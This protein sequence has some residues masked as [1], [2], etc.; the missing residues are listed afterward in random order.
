MEERWTCSGWV[1][2][3]RTA[4][5]LFPTEQA[6]SFPRFDPVVIAVGIRGQ[7]WDGAT[8][9]QTLRYAV[10]TDDT[11]PM[12]NTPNQDYNQP[13]RCAQD[14]H[15]PLNDNF[16]KLD[17]DVPIVDTEA[18]RGDYDP[19]N[20]SLFFATDTGHVYLW[21][22][23]DWGPLSLTWVGRDGTDLFEPVHGDD[24]VGGIAVST[25][26]LDAD[27][28]S[29]PSSSLD[30]DWRQPGPG[31]GVD[32]D[33]V[34]GVGGTIDKSLSGGGTLEHG[35]NLTCGHP[36]NTV[37][38]GTAGATICGGGGEITT[39]SGSDSLSNEVGGDFGV[40]TGGQDNT[41]DGELGTV[42][43]GGSNSCTG[44][45]GTVAG[46]SGNEATADGA[47]VGG[48]FSNSAMD[49][50]C[51]VAG[52]KTNAA[53][54]EGAC[55][56]G[57]LKNGSN[58]KASTVGGGSDNGASGSGATISGGKQNV[59]DGEDVTIAG[60]C[61]NAGF[62][63]GATVGGGVGNSS[64]GKGATNTGGFDNSCTDDFSS[65]LGG[66]N[67]TVSGKGSTNCGG[68]DNS[69]GADFGCNVGGKSNSV[70]GPGGC[71]T[72][73]RQNEVR[74][75]NASVTGGQDNTASGQNATVLGGQ[76]NTSDGDLSLTAGRQADANGQ[77]GATV[78]AD[79]SSTPASA[80]DSNQ[81]VVQAGGSRSSGAA[82]K[83]LSQSDG[84]AGVT[85]TAGSGS[86]SSLSARAAKT[87]VEP[88]DEDDVLDRVAD[89]DVSTWRYT[90]QAADVRHMGP[91]AEAFHEAFGLGADEETISTVDAD[92]V[93][94]A[95]ISAL[96]RKLDEKDGR[97]DEL[98][99]RVETL[100]AA[101]SDVRDR[102]DEQTVSPA[103]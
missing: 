13:D 82:A 55:V 78:L 52:G 29:Q 54:G 37:T 49:Q 10:P 69:L 81:L 71:V 31:W 2:E 89:L 95:A 48:G 22:G 79:G 65:N 56:G 85:L 33:R 102:L 1:S 36:T 34:V 38:D 59:C 92:G 97:I 99:S 86:W 11:Q 24:P 91:M 26:T 50:S 87:D 40:C 77:I 66:Q 27:S 101:L 19:A 6:G 45:A 32:G 28:S 98:E 14:W 83:V 72:G 70:V 39:D 42:G 93:A 63:Q 84:S 94:L 8:N 90:G 51:T 53:T 25:V 57:G 7:L 60:G 17:T 9:F 5:T 43:G 21:N 58:G 23:S 73:G 67:N 44:R 18:N 3:S 80:T 88:V 76:A 100:E 68:I 30:F 47:C 4:A 15:N 61:G 64:N 75:L 62:K 20:G 35:G 12:S 16:A 46:G 96:S 74:G 103:R 41:V